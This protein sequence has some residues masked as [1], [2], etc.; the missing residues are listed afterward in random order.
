[1]LLIARLVLRA[2]GSAVVEGNF[3]PE[4]AAEELRE[5]Q[6]ETP[7]RFVQILCLADP[8]TCLARYRERADSARRHPVH[9]V[10]GEESEASV[11]R[12]LREGLWERPI[13]LDGELFRL[14]TNDR[15][16][17]DALADAIE[18]ALTEA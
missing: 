17:V 12:R 13:P 14:N 10:G 9:R 15:V 7:F 2:G 5:L 16:D 18:A 3:T 1:M 8:E 4:W 6:A 11:E